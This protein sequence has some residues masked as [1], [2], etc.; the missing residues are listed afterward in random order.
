[1][2][3]RFGCGPFRLELVVLSEVDLTV[4]PRGK[5]SVPNYLHIWPKQ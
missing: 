1:M 5:S 4:F 2:G 3:S